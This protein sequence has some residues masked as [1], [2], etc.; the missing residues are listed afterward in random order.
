MISVLGIVAP[1]WLNAISNLGIVGALL[2]W[3]PRHGPGQTRF[4]FRDLLGYF[5]FWGR[6][7]EVSLSVIT[8]TVALILYKLFNATAGDA[9]HIGKA[10]LAMQ[11]QPAPAV[12]TRWN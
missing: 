9:Y 11:L 3:R 6:V 8:L 5:M 7:T 12:G 1:F 4:Q 10:A 2:W